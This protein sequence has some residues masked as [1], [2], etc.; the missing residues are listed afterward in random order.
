MLKDG[1]CGAVVGGPIWDGGGGSD[2]LQDGTCKA[3]PVW[4]NARL[5]ASRLLTDGEEDDGVSAVV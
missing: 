4:R 5:A 1:G 3:D 2:G